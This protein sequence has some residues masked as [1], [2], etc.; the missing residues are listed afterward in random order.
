[1]PTSRAGRPAGDAEAHAWA[2]VLVRRGLL[3][4]AVAL[5]GGQWLIQHRPACVPQVLDGPQELLALAARAQHILR[6]QEEHR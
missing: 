1:M 2:E 4:A 6:L 5:P 3:H